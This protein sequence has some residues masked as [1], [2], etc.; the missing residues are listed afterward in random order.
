MPAAYATGASTSPTDLL[1]TLAA[2]LTTQG[3]TQD[4]LS[5]E[6]AGRRLH[7]HKNG[8]YLNVRAAENEDSLFPN[9]GSGLFGNLPGYGWLANLGTGYD[10]GEPWYNQPGRPLANGSSDGIGVGMR[11]PSGNVVGYHIFDDG[12]DNITV[13]V[14]ITPGK[15]QYLGFGPS[16]VKKGYTWDSSYIFA[17]LTGHYGLNNPATTAV[18]GFVPGPNPLWPMGSWNYQGAPPHSK[19]L[20]ASTGFIKLDASVFAG[21]WASCIAVDSSSGLQAQFDGFTGRYVIG[22]VHGLSDQLGFPGYFMGGVIENATRGTGKLLNA[23]AFQRTTPIPL[24]QYYMDVVSGRF[25]PLGYLPSIFRF[26]GLDPGATGFAEKQVL[27]IGGKDYMLFPRFMV[28]K[29]A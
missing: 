6:G 14:E 10:G 7:T 19:T 25:K 3:W 29:A 23:T 21:L 1:N 13:V 4:D 12:F 8:D 15:Y 24:H 16:L 26:A 20:T 18:W 2:F 27:P 28:R 5:T 17:S 11:L 22:A 9:L